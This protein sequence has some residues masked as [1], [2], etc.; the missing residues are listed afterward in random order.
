MPGSARD[1]YHELPTGPVITATSGPVDGETVPWDQDTDATS[2]ASIGPWA[3][4]LAI[5]ALITSFFVGW[6]LPLGVVAVIGAIL[7]L[8]RFESRPIAV[9]ALVLGAL[10]VVYSIGWLVWAIPQL[11]A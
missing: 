7:A 5:L 10:A 8:R 2:R 4:G 11:P 3:L 6:M 9:W 1:G